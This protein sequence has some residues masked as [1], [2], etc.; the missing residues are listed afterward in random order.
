[1][2]LRA[3]HHVALQVRDLAAMES[4]YRTVL[5]LPVQQR[6]P[7]GKGGERSV[8]LGLDGGFI[9]LEQ[10]PA[11]LPVPPRGDFADGRVGFYVVALRIEASERAA[12]EARLAA[13]GVAVER[14]TGFSLFFRDPEGNRLAVSHHPTAV[15]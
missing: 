3:F 2:T 4:F 10:A 8:W 9:A 1:V 6:W 14:R 15:T 11:D 12:W 13:A 7:D 5:G